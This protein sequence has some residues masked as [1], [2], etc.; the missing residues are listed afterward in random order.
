MADTESLTLAFLTA[1]P[2]EAARVLERLPGNQAGEF[3][4]RVP[5]RAGAPAL[6]AML[7][8]AAA[9]VI[10]TL[11]DAPA[12]ALLTS[13]GVQAAVGVLRYV[14][15]PRRTRLIEGLPT[16]TALASRL[17]LGYPEDSVGA[18]MD[19]DVIALAPETPVRDALARV[20]DGEEAHVER[21]HTI[22]GERRLIGIVELA[23]LLRAPGTTTLEVLM[24]K[25]SAVLTAMT[26]LTGAASQRGWERSSALPVVERGGRLI[27]IL[28]RATLARAL[29]RNRASGQPVADASLAGMFARGYWDTVSALAEVAIALLPTAKPVHPEKADTT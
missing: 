3:F 2:A 19:P 9:R 1:H 14:A 20:R 4:A 15:E 29:A 28:P 16:A 26:P 22:D 10:G 21:L 11:D 7:P 12:L 27:G 5:A 23:T 8:T 18:W 17:L 24:R 25:P 6:V 13:V